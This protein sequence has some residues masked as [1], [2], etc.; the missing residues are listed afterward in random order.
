MV[1]IVVPEF[2]A[3]ELVA[4]ADREVGLRRRVYPVWVRQGRMSQEKADEEIA[5]M[6]AIC[7]LLRAAEA[8][9]TEQSTV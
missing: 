9:W 5:K 4:C 7:S 2:T 8:K 3:A 1:G 6:Q